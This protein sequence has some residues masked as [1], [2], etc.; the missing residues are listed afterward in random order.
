MELYISKKTDY[1]NHKKERQFILL[2]ILTFKEKSVK[3]SCKKLFWYMEGYWK[4]KKIRGR[5]EVR[6]ETLVL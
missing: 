5:E 1:F 4:K 2:L 3:I 6:K